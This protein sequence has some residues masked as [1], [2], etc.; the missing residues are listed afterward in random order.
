[1]KQ[2]LIQLMISTGIFFVIDILWITRV[3]KPLYMHYIP[4]IIRSVPY[5]PA[6]GLFY[7]LFLIGL[8]YFAI[9]PN[10]SMAKTIGQGSAYGL[11]TYATYTLTNHAVLREWHWS[12]SVSDCAWGLLLGGFVAGMTRFIY[13]P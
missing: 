13:T 4:S 5:M 7:A 12:L 6:A 10:Y 8:C 3:V 2:M 11:F 1:M 9:W